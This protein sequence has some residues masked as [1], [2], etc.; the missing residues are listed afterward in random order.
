MLFALIKYYDGF[1]LSN[2]H[3]LCFSL[4]KYLLKCS[5]P[6]IAQ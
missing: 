5:V 6:E 4:I 1:S 2:M 3:A